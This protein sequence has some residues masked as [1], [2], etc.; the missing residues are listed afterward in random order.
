MTDAQLR[1]QFLAEIG[2][3]ED[4]LDLDFAKLIRLIDLPDDMSLIEMIN[5]LDL[6]KDILA[7]ADLDGKDFSEQSVAG[8]TFSDSNIKNQK[9]ISSTITNTKFVN[10]KITDCNFSGSSIDQL[11]FEECKIHEGLFESL[12]ATD[13]S[14]RNCDLSYFNMSSMNAANFEIIEGSI[15]GAALLSV[16][17][18][19]GRFRPKFMNACNFSGAV[20]ISSTF[21]RIEELHMV[22][23]DGARLEDC[24]L[25]MLD[26][27]KCSFREAQLTRS[28]FFGSAIEASA[29]DGADI[30]GAYFGKN[31]GLSRRSEEEFAERGAIFPER[32]F[33]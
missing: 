31:E 18:R 24:A 11:G 25:S 33:A 17:I 22:D 15:S 16:F 10:C 1:A 27:R 26:L 13:L 7:F 12:R 23:F 19:S 4:P 29:F 3:S 5:K 6:P 21:E 8:Y 14:F 2:D 32:V 30:T 9:F 20:I 28:N